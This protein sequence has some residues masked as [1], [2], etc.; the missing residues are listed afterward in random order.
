MEI[1]IQGQFITPAGA[2][3]VCTRKAIPKTKVKHGI[4]ASPLIILLF[5]GNMLTSLFTEVAG[6][7]HLRVVLHSLFH[8]V[9]VLCPNKFEFLDI[10]VTFGG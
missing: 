4:I 2:S 5:A 6:E 1:I 7:G 9:L 3:L 10:G 8:Q